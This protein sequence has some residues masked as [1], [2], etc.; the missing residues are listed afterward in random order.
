MTRVTPVKKRDPPFASQQNKLI[1]GMNSRL[2]TDVAPHA[3]TEVSTPGESVMLPIPTIVWLYE[4]TEDMGCVVSSSAGGSAVPMSPDAAAV[5]YD[6]GADSYIAEPGTMDDLYFPTAELDPDMVAGYVEGDRVWVTFNRQSGRMEVLGHPE[7]RCDESSSSSSSG[8]S[9]SSGSSSS[10]GSS[11]SSGS[12]S[13]EEASSGEECC[14]G[15]AW[16]VWCP[17]TPPECTP[18]SSSSSS[19][20]ECPESY[21]SPNP[22]GMWWYLEDKSDVG[23]DRYDKPE[24]EG[25][26]YGQVEIKCQ[27][28]CVTSSSSS[29]SGECECPDAADCAEDCSEVLCATITGMTGDCE[30]A[31]QIINLTRFPG[32]CHWTR[33]VPHDWEEGFCANICIMIWCECGDSGSGSGSSGEGCAW[34]M[35]VDMDYFP[36]AVSNPSRWLSRPISACDYPDCP[37]LGAYDLYNI[38]NGYCPDQTPT[39]VISEGQCPSSSSSGEP[40]SSSSSS[41]SSS[42]EA[43]SSSSSSGECVVCV[44]S[45]PAVIIATIAGVAQNPAASSSGTECED[46]TAWNAAWK[47]DYIGNCVWE[48]TTDLP[49]NATRIWVEVSEAA[50][51]VY[52]GLFVDFVGNAEAVEFGGSQAG[53]TIDCTAIGAPTYDSDSDPSCDWTGATV[54]VTS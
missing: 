39:V 20:G 45:T 40:A 23:A 2:E 16:W 4:L 11:G 32:S 18:S 5:F 21:V 8:S 50:G 42:G 53:S 48:K 25:Q 36:D 1:E 51:T 38:F 14:G 30:C 27:C 3:G 37:P 49:C 15:C 54:N 28:V 17:C 24:V 7:K 10:S 41:S 12:S 31:N 6:I 29:S 22:P 46:C 33:C 19:S 34:Y 9:G 26:Y 47:L 13:G 44:E 43:S 52:Y 35:Q